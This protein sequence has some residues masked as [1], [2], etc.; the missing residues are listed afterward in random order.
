MSTPFPSRKP[1]PEEV[2]AIAQHGTV[3]SDIMRWLEEEDDG[4]VAAEIERLRS[5]D[6]PHATVVSRSGD[7]SEDRFLDEF[8]EAHRA[9]VFGGSSIV[10]APEAA[11]YAIEEEIS[12]GAQG[13]VFLAR[14]TAT[15]RLVALKV[16]LRGAFASPRQLVRFERE[17]EMVASLKHPGIVTVYD[18]GTTEDGR[19]WLAMEY[20][21]GEP[22]DGWL[23]RKTD[24]APTARHR[25]ETALIADVCDAVAAA[26]RKGVIHRDLKPDNVLVDSDGRPHVLDFG[27]AKP[28][29]DSEW[30]SSQLEVTMAGEFMGTFAYASPEQVSGDPDLI[31]VRTDVFAIGVMLYEAVLGTRPYILEGS[32]ADVVRTIAEAAPIPPRSVDPSLDR[33]LE[34]ILLRS[35]DRDLD[36]RYQGP[37]DLARDLRHW[38]AGEPIEARRDD[39]WYVAR[40]LLKRH[41]IAVSGGIAAVGLL[42]AFGV[43]M[44]VAWDRASTA[45][46]RLRGTVGMVSKVLGTADAENIDQP[47]AAS[48]IGEM[49]AQW[50]R[51]VDTDLTDYPEV[52]TAVRLDLAQNYIG[53]GRYEE[54]EQ[55]LD[56]AAETVDL[57]VLQPSPEAGNLLH[58]RGRLHYKRADYGL[59]VDAYRAAVAHRLHTDPLAE[60]TAESTLHLGAALQRAGMHQESHR[61]LEDALNRHRELVLA[62]SSDEEQLSRRT[63][64]ANVLNTMAIAHLT[65]RPE[66]ALPLVR[67]TLDHLESISADPKAD[68]RIGRLQHNLGDCL[69]RLDRFEEGEAALLAALR[70]K[71]LQG[72]KTSIANTHAA[73]A[74]LAIAQRDAESAGDHLRQARQLRSGRLPE[75]HPS[76]HDEAL[77]DIEIRL[78]TG[79]LDGAQSLL[80]TIDEHSDSV[81]RRASHDRLRGLLL[82][83]RGEHDQA[84]MSL[85]KAL[86]A[87]IDSTGARSPQSRKCMQSLAKLVEARG[88]TEEAAAL[89][90][91]ALPPE[92]STGDVGP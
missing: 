80:S 84:E 36:R 35:I 27:L 19:A 52:A 78:L 33:D 54:A 6:D 79:D 86:A 50:L 85:H 56:H 11:G 28:V 91:A 12:R 59:A 20:V 90:H 25:T 69:A 68:W 76:Q 37:A 32:I 21:D 63:A 62:A 4:S 17:V 8:A 67:E 30:E 44:T 66:Q 71:Q 31:D 5:A 7:T 51:V 18:S 70:I 26:H 60:T 53:S 9:G 15:R 34:T 22:L 49:M 43:F 75:D 13:A 29:D 72:S 1:T 81:Q 82:K 92:T 61:V 77:I 46:E 14:Q 40:K 47:L 89:R 2:R 65:N 10:E 23:C 39:A 88:Q 38:M 45:N 83:A 57:S 16:L 42:I 55:A 48:S 58:L 87:F 41:W 64:L 3:A 74:R 24:E 73:L